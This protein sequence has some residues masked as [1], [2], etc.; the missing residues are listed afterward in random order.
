V[1]TSPTN[2]QIFDRDTTRI[3]LAWTS[4][5]LPP[6]VFYVVTLNRYINSVFSRK[7]EFDM[8]ENRFQLPSSALANVPAGADVKFEWTVAIRRAKVNVDGTKEWDPTLNVT[9][10]TFTFSYRSPTATLVPTWTVPP[11]TPVPTK[12]SQ[13]SPPQPAT[14]PAGR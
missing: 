5:E 7:D 14:T 12:R 11:V 10:Q 8:R 2:G 13:G 3:I 6:D 1:L 4:G 9:S